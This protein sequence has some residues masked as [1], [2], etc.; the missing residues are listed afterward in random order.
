[1]DFDLRVIP[2]IKKLQAFVQDVAGHPEEVEDEVADANGD[3]Y[4]EKMVSAGEVAAFKVHEK[5]KGMQRICEDKDKAMTAIV[6]EVIE[7][8]RGVVETKR[9]STKLGVRIN[10][11]KRALSWGLCGKQSG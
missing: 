4:F 8:F 11:F 1:M 6:A 2:S 9:S 5:M 7:L 3:R 10:D